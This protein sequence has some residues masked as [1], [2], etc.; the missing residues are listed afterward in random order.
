MLKDPAPV[1][2]ITDL[3]ESCINIS[4]RP[5][6]KVP[7]FSAAQLELYQAIVEQFRA[8][9]IEIPFPQRELCVLGGTRLEVK[10]S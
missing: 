9:Q 4:V 7:D 6:V 3:D 8:N 2:G 5:W 1:V 10:T